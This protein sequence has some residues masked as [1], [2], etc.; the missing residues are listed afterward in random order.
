MDS[1]RVGSQG[2]TV[3]VRTGGAFRDTG[4]RTTDEIPEALATGIGGASPARRKRSHWVGGRGQRLR[5]R[6]GVQPSIQGR[7]RSS[8]G[9][10]AQEFQAHRARGL[11]WRSSAVVRGEYIER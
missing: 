11:T 8:A 2:C 3:A 7:I 5:N 1:G 10:L 6:S 4:R 9:D